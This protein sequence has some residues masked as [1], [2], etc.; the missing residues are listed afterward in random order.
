MM[1]NWINTASH[2]ALNAQESVKENVQEIVET[3]G[4]S[5]PQTEQSIGELIRFDPSR[6]PGTLKHMAIG[7]L[8]IFVVMGVIILTVYGLNKLGTAMQ[9]KKDAKKNG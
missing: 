2:F 8:A 9:K 5:S 6:L 7:M 4:A 1:M 3:I